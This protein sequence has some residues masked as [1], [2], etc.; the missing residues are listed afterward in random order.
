MYVFEENDFVVDDLCTGELNK[1]GD[2]EDMFFYVS[3][4]PKMVY[5]EKI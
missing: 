1:W 5:G 4:I 3:E 2:N